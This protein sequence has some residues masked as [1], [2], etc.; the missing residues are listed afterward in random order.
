[1][2]RVG[3]YGGDVTGSW[4]PSTKRAMSAFMDRVNATLPM[5]E[6]DYIL[7]TLVQGH[8]EIACGAGCPAGQTIG[9]NGRCVPKAVLARDARKSQREDAMAAADTRKTDDSRVAE[10]Q[11]AADRLKIAEAKREQDRLRVKRSDDERRAAAAMASATYRPAS[12]TAAGSESKKTVVAQSGQEQLP[13]L[14][15]DLSLPAPGTDAA[16]APA[17]RPDGMMSIGGPRMATAELTD[18]AAA[19]TPEAGPAPV[20]RYPSDDAGIDCRRRAAPGRDRNEVGPG[21]RAG[22]ARN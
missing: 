8:A 21:R 12:E 1:M 13:W 5:D 6:P 9:E 7:L 17:A 4:T 19:V 2:K 10:E 3:C 11:K 20:T 22:P 15:D 16:R 18:S 14:N